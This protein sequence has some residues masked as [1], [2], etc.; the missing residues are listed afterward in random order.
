MKA[1][2]RL[3]RIPRINPALDPRVSSLIARPRAAC[4]T[5]LR[6]APR[7][8]DIGIHVV[9]PP[10][11]IGQRDGLH[12]AQV[13]FM[14]RSR[15]HCS[16]RQQGQGG[17]ADWKFNFHPF[18]WQMQLQER[19]RNP[20]LCNSLIPPLA[21][22]AFAPCLSHSRNYHINFNPSCIWRAEVTVRARTPALA[23]SIELL[24][25]FKK[26]GAAKL[27][28]FRILKTSNRS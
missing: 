20:L 6:C 9:D 11:D 27:G 10:F 25:S 7:A 17:Q 26:L 5:S 8:F 4:S 24:A 22:T 13:S 16:Q 18:C 12:R 3:A 19:W 2:T 23:V 1:S 15:R 28:W 14:L 21:R